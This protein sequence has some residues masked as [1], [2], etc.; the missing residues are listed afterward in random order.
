MEVVSENKF[1]NTTKVYYGVVKQVNNKKCTISINGKNFVL[2][3]YGGV[4]FVNKTYAAI[5]PQNNINQ[6]CVLGESTLQSLVDTV[7]MPTAKE[8]M[9]IN[10]AGMNFTVSKLSSTNQLGTLNWTVKNTAAPDYL[11]HRVGFIGQT[12]GIYLYDYTAQKAIWYIPK[13]T[14][15]LGQVFTEIPDNSDIDDYYLPGTYKISYSASAATMTNL[16]IASAGV[17]YV[18]ASTGKAISASSTWKYLVQEYMTYHGYLYTRKGDSGSGTS[19]T[20]GNWYRYLTTSSLPLP[21]SSGGTGATDAGTALTNLGVTEG[22]NYIKFPNGTLIQWGN[23][24]LNVENAL[25]QASS[26]GIY[27]GS[28]TLTFPIAFYDINIGVR[29]QVK[30]STG[31]EVPCGML[32]QLP[33]QALVR[34]YDFYARPA[35]DTLYK[36]N[37][38]AIGRWK[39]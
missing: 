30:Y 39:A 21:V 14:M 3:V 9:G 8:I 33:T 4:V 12:E 13:E 18:R 38:M 15:P 10:D 35:S 20:W 34:I 16:P 11:N 36:L 22:K 1:K 27:Y 29:G 26:S 7:T 19:V 17:L 28:A 37:W 31:F 6:A 2:P 5:I 25:T 24:T 32:V 23:V